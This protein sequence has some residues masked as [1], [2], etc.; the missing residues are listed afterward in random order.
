MP[1]TIKP[2][3]LIADDNASILT[4]LGQA[5]ATWGYRVVG[6]PDKSELLRQL[7]AETPAV[8]LQDLYFGQENGIEL[9]QEVLRLWPG[10]PVVL[11]TG[12]GSIDHAVAAIKHGAYDFL[13]KPPD[14]HRLRVTLT[15]AVEKQ[16]LSQRLRSL[17]QLVEPRGALHRIW[18]ECAA[19][20]ELRDLIARVA[21]TDATAL[22]LGES[23][24]G[25]ELVARALHECS[26][27]KQGP[28]VPANMAALPREL[29]ESALFGHEKGAFTG[30]DQTQ[31]G[32]FEA[33]NQ[34]T[35]FLDEIGEMDAQLQAKLLRFLQEHTLSRVGSPLPRRINVRVIA[36]TNRD[37]RAEVRSGRF[38][39]DLYYRLNVVPILVPPLRERRDDIPVLATQFLRQSA[40]RHR[41]EVAR[42]SPSAL[43]A[44]MLHDWPG[45]VRQLENLVERLVI[46]SSSPEIDAALLPEEVRTERPDV[47]VPAAGPQPEQVC[48]RMDELE[49]QAVHQ[50]LRQA[51]GNVRQAARLLGVGQATMYR[52]I[53]RYGLTSSRGRESSCR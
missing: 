28:F 43:E 19:I 36:A 12:H 40:A 52:K 17:E 39:E 22:I 34:G 46:L 4:V 20:R 5:I 23:G 7:A 32:F 15:H 51:R 50:A 10:L 41:K 42:F 11:L 53:H 21:P 47:V 49:K 13:T 45:N 48:T 18:G 29:S 24:T 3:I 26:T 2:L 6:A 27:R 1:T 25:K 31:L 16:A 38:R 37:L 8:L 30:A 33:A 9:L 14:L 35:V 44:L